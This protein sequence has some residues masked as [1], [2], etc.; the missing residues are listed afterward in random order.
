[1]DAMNFMKVVMRYKSEIFVY[2]CALN[3]FLELNYRGFLKILCD[4]SKA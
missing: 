4:F 3:Y 2:R 1:M